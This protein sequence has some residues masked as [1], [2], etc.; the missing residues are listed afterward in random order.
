MNDKGIIQNLFCALNGCLPYEYD[1]KH[2]YGTERGDA[3]I[4]SKTNS[5]RSIYITP[6]MPNGNAILD[7]TLYDDAYADDPIEIV[8]W[9]LDDQ[10]LALT[11]L[12]TYIEKTI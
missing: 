3:I 2:I 11:D 12:I 5:E 6:N 7:I 10:D 8:Q 1:E 4:I 9:D